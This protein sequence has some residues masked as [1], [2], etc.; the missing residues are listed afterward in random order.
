MDGV[1]VCTKLCKIIRE[2]ELQ[3]ESVLMNNEL[4][5]MAQYRSLM[6]EVTAL[7][8]MHQEIQDLLKK[9]MTDDDE[10]TIV[11]GTFGQQT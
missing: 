2:R 11:A 4:Q 10:G 1:W 3:I 5:D 6:G 8:I 7:G 9:G